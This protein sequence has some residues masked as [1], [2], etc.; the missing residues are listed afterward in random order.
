[1]PGTVRRLL[2]RLTA[3]LLALA[4]VALVALAGVS[5]HRPIVCWRGGG[6]LEGAGELTGP[7]PGGSRSQAEFAGG[8]FVFSTVTEAFGLEHL[9]KDQADW[10]VARWEQIPQPPATP[11]SPGQAAAAVGRPAL[12][13][14]M[15]RWTILPWPAAGVLLIYPTIRL[16]RA[17]MRLRRERRAAGRVFD[18]ALFMI[19]KRARV[20]P[21][22]SRRR[23][24]RHHRHVHVVG[25]PLVIHGAVC[26]TC[27]RIFAQ[28]N[29]DRAVSQCPACRERAAVSAD[30]SSRENP[31]AC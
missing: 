12:P 17:L 21:S 10:M 16:T 13:G 22:A 23:S 29:A 9:R 8:W 25:P 11:P 15:D 2:G 19:D 6:G 5:F 1:M 14:V 26:A 4:G 7:A 18:D 27:G 28:T 30:S 20:R 24:G 31:S 3:V